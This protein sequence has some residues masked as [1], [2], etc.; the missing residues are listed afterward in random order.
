MNCEKSLM[1][2]GGDGRTRESA[3]LASRN[4]AS[5]HARS[6][7]NQGFRIA[8]EGAGNMAASVVLRRLSECA[9]RGA[10]GAAIVR[11]KPTAKA[12]Q[13]CSSARSLLKAASQTAIL[14]SRITQA[15]TTKPRMGALL[16]GSGHSPSQTLVMVS[17]IVR[18]LF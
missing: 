11:G 10:A 8:A 1:A 16:S 7:S 2:I 3:I 4:G 13:R 14:P 6:R 5:A 17:A 9:S 18:K 12:R 15:S